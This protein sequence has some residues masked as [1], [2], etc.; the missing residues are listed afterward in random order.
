M[1]NIIVLFLTI[2]TG[3][4]SC[5]IDLDSKSENHIPVQNQKN[6]P[7]ISG[8]YAIAADQKVTVEWAP[9]SSEYKTTLTQNKCHR[10]QKWNSE[11]K[12]YDSYLIIDEAG[13][14]EDVTFTGTD[15]T[16][17]QKKV[18]TGLENVTLDNCQNSPFY[19]YTLRLYKGENLLEE[20]TAEATPAGSF[21]DLYNEGTMNV[22]ANLLDYDSPVSNTCQRDDEKQLSYIEDFQIKSIK[23][24]GL[25][26]KNINLHHNPSAIKKLVDDG[27]FDYSSFKNKLE[28]GEDIEF[29]RLYRNGFRF[30]LTA[31]IIKSNL[32]NTGY[33]EVSNYEIDTATGNGNS[34]ENLS[35][36]FR[37][38]TTIRTKGYKTP[39][40]G[41]EALYTISN[42]AK[43]TFGSIKTASSQYANIELK[44]GYLNL[45]SL[46]AGKCFQITSSKAADWRNFK[47]AKKALDA[48]K[49]AGQTTCTQWEN[50][51]TT[52]SNWA[53]YLINDDGAR[54]D[55]AL[56]I[57]R[58]YR[59]VNGKENTSIPLTLY[60]PAGQYRISTA[61][62]ASVQ[63][64]TIRGETVTR[65]LTPEQL[66]SFESTFKLGDESGSSHFSGSVLYTDNGSGCNHLNI[67][68]PAN[69]VVVDGLT[70]ESR[71]TD[72]KRTYWYTGIDENG[73]KTGINFIGYGSLEKTMADEQ[74]YS[75][76]VMI[77]QCHDV[78]VKNCE[79]IITSHIRDQ[80]KF[81]SDWTASK[82]SLYDFN[83][84]GPEFLKEGD[85]HGNLWKSGSLE[86][87]GYAANPYV[88]WCDLHTDK[89]FTN[90][91]F[92][93]GWSNV[94]VDNC[95]MYNMAGVFRGANMGY[96]D[97]YGEQCFNGTVN[98]CT[99]YHNCHD[100]QIGIFTL[101][102]NALNYKPTECMDGVNFTNN[103][104]YAMRDAHVDKIKSRVMVFT[105]GYNGSKN[106][107]NVKVDGN[108]FYLKN[109]PSKCF[110]FDGGIDQGRNDTWI[111]NNTFDIIENGGFYI[112]ESTRSYVHINNNTFNYKCN[113]SSGY[114]SGTCVDARFSKD[115]SP[116]EVEF[117]GNTI[118]VDGNSG[119][120]IFTTDGYPADG[121]FNNNIIN[122]EGNANYVVT[123]ARE[124][125]NN[126]MNVKGRFNG[127]FC[128]RGK[129][130]QDVIIDNNRIIT[131]FNDSEDDYMKSTNEGGFYETGNSGFTFVEAG[132][133]PTSDRKLII[134][135]NK[136]EAPNCTR[137]NKHFLRY[138]NNNL[139][140]I[141]SGNKVQKYQYLRRVNNSDL[142][143]IIFLNN[144]DNYGRKFKPEEWLVPSYKE[145][146]EKAYYEYTPETNSYRVKKNFGLYD[147]PC[148][149]DD[150]SH[151]T[152]PITTIADAVYKNKNYVP[153][154]KFPITLQEIGKEAFMNSSSGFETLP[155]SLKIIRQKAFYEANNLGINNGTS[156]YNVT[157]TIDYKIIIP[158]NVSIIE[159]KA[160]CFTNR[161]GTICCE[162]E[163]KPSGWADDWYENRTISKNING[164]T[165]TLNTIT[166][167]W[168]YKGK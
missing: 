167:E 28:P 157:G 2:F 124:T 89:Q 34:L 1:K 106:I 6:T 81:P 74:W 92:F 108:Y 138:T 26:E 122:I 23:G 31:R 15:M 16:K 52:H 72:S 147:I 123:G 143:K 162:A 69:N 39:G 145:S 84:N 3:L 154:C 110:T 56:K 43:Y 164:S 136:I 66:D 57:L 152:L 121:K 32:S 107:T 151:G 80:A 159:S 53:K 129:I 126:V 104:V 68:G 130:D 25:Y 156:H 165:K 61:V 161:V 49:K 85:A 117:S 19:S 62:N 101:T 51:K 134:T 65:H 116:Y 90:V 102:P 103:R 12:K 10:D 144:F 58:N 94:K 113:P 135:N 63:N 44:S 42:R 87:Y 40:D 71:E 155:A 111:T 37:T 64:Y 105:V 59:T 109:L 22:W 14:E 67:Y 114:I 13:D 93:S 97:F 20:D 9:V 98:N 33:T 91:S 11:T 139:S 100:E 132:F 38:G 118:N 150:G 54:I 128:G 96:L 163:S 46:G 78:L 141:A 146:T 127:F 112:F 137:N 48:A 17:T 115:N 70:F 30:F 50:F 125:R 140:V 8:F 153:R 41:G 73:N 99:M 76:E 86:Y 88:E 82:N 4:I 18:F 35:K 166:V 149:Y 148:F 142:G 158:K 77:S 24:V 5:S 36:S 7:L 21:E 120:S 160:F 60:I 29:F 131:L 47:D 95:L 27:G 168:G 133:S 119:V 45:T 75:R 55:E 83:F 79:F